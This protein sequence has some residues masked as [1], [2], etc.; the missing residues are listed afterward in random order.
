VRDVLPLTPGHPEAEHLLKIQGQL[1]RDIYE[2]G[3]SPGLYRVAQSQEVVGEKDDQGVNFGPSRDSHAECQARLSGSLS[4]VARHQPDHLRNLVISMDDVEH[5]Q[6]GELCDLEPG[7]EGSE[8]KSA[9]ER[10]I[11]GPAAC[12]HLM[13]EPE[14]RLPG[15]ATRLARLHEDRQPAP[16]SGVH[17]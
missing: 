5:V 1:R 16:R 10:K 3:K 11:K 13:E 2:S 6:H 7:R 15:R 14:R 4:R 8:A 17:L 12:G 9:P